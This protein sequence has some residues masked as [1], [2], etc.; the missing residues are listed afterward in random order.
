MQQDGLRLSSRVPLAGR[1]K[2]EAVM[3]TFK[4]G[5]RTFLAA[6][7]AAGVAA[8][9]PA[10]TSPSSVQPAGGGPKAEWEAEWERLAA[11]AKREGKLSVFTLAG[12]GYRKALDQ[13]QEAFG[14][15]AD[16]QSESSASIWVPK[17][18]RER[19]AGVYTFDVVI[20]P[21]N[22]A[23]LRLKPKGAWDPVRP[24]IFRPDVLDDKAW[25]DGFDG[26]FMDTDKHL[27]FSYMN[28]TN[29]NVSI[30]TRQVRPDEIKGVRDL[31]DPKWKGRLIITDVRVGSTFL[32]LQAV[33]NQFPDGD[34]IIRKLLIEQQPT[35]LRD[36]RQR[37]EAIV[38]A[39]AP[40]VLGVTYP[41]LQEFREQGVA[42]HVKFL[43]LPEMDY[44]VSWTVLLYNKAPHPNAAKLFINWLLTREGQIT[45][46][47][48]VPSN[49][50]R[51][52]VEPFNADAVASPGKK[53][54]FASREEEYGKQ[55]GTQ[56]FLNG[57]AGVT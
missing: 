3:E 21:P 54:Y 25:R 50:A 33:R 7:S 27:A 43:D 44:V 17:M 36:A 11:A 39:K 4:I 18:E 31:L 57:L 51:T 6:G 42:D 53:Y 8:C 37:A 47:K 28:D 22:S 26:Q 20:V 19:D 41:S 30:D 2:E 12:T 38:R 55:E 52:D 49:S 14:I 46:N 32:S 40:I 23:L 34:E 29:H 10:A 5:R 1:M 13:F 35:F 24:V 48:P 45:W 56:T 16:H 9:A 15:E